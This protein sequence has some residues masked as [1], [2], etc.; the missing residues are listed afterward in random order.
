MAGVKE[1][2]GGKRAGAGRKPTALSDDLLAQI[3]PAP[4]K[5]L[6]QSRWYTRAT[7]VLTDAYLRG[8]GPRVLKMLNQVRISAGAASKVLPHDI[9]FEAQRRLARDEAEI[10]NDAGGADV[11]RR[12]ADDVAQR[13]RAV[14]RD[15]Q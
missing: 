15:P 12:G 2:S 5:P 11:T 14:R 3:G 1:R 8:G 9:V 13:A 7:I 6:D 10:K 4:D